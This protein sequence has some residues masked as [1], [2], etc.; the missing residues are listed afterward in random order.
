VSLIPKEEVLSVCVKGKTARDDCPRESREE[1]V[2]RRGSEGGAGREKGRWK[3]GRWPQGNW[4]SILRSGGKYQGN[5]V[6]EEG[7]LES[8]WSKR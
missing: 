8:Q 7:D 6:E 5:F 4:K 3:K 2:L 1:E